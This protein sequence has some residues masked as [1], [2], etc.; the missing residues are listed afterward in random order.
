MFSG[1]GSVW[2]V[3]P[4]AQDSCVFTQKSAL[5]G[6]G[7]SFLAPAD[8]HQSLFVCAPCSVLLF[9]WPHRLPLVAYGFP[10]P[11]PNDIHVV[12]IVSLA[13]ARPRSIVD[14][15]LVWGSC[16]NFLQHKRRDQRAEF[17]CLCTQLAA[18]RRSPV[19]IVLNQ[20]IVRQGEK[21]AW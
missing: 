10:P 4:N 17:N 3:G 9:P 6:R 12:L 7:L 20:P 19:I 15:P 11:T 8:L 1:T 5:C 13:I 16:C 18:C 14:C 2:T 21:P